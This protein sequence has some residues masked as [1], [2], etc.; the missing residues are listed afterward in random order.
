MVATGVGRVSWV[1]PKFS[2]TKTKGSECELA[3]LWRIPSPGYLPDLYYWL[4]GLKVRTPASVLEQAPAGSTRT[5]A[6]SSAQKPRM[7]VWLI[8]SGTA[9]HRVTRVD[10]THNR[11]GTSGERVSA[12]AAARRVAVVGEH[13]VNQ[14]SCGRA[15][16]ASRAQRAAQ[17]RPGPEHNQPSDTLSGRLLR[18]W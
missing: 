8:E 7:P 2:Q 13:G 12:L 9:T 3:A 1:K 18:Q 17:V 10:A 11:A 16:S 15:R 5:T 6:S 4:S 14:A